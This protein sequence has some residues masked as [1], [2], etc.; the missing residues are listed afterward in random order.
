MAQ[1]TQEINQALTTIGSSFLKILSAMRTY[2][3]STQS[4]IE[5]VR[6]A[7]LRPDKVNAIEMVCQKMALTVN[8]LS[9]KLEAEISSLETSSATLKRN[10]N[11]IAEL[12][13]SQPAEARELKITMRELLGQ[14]SQALDQTKSLRKS[15]IG[16]QSASDS[17][18]GPSQRLILVLDQIV[19]ATDYQ[20][21][22]YKQQI[23]IIGQKLGE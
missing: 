20:V 6:A 7:S 3:T 22:F 23:L 1:N 14:T 18:I 5:E 10:E 15:T 2:S 12:V 8:L 13:L 19:K 11:T 9:S 17:L 16:M 21:Q 4:H